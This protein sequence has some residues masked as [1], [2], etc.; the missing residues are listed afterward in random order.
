MVRRSPELKAEIVEYSKHHSGKETSIKYGCTT[1]TVSSLRR[2]AG[3]R[4]P[5]RIEAYKAA[6]KDHVDK[7]WGII[8]SARYHGIGTSCFYAYVKNGGSHPKKPE[9]S[10][11]CVVDSALL[12]WV[13]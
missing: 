9:N 7:G 4:K 6:Y 2:E 1:S 12:M 8:K 5:S 11:N 3:V 10:T 13:K